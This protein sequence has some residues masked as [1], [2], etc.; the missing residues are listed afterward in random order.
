[1][2]EDLHFMQ[3]LDIPTN[4]KVVISRLPFKLRERWRAK[5]H[6]IWEASNDR[7]HFPDMV[8]FLER[9]VTLKVQA[10]HKGLLS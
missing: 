10:Y 3:E 1:M 4:M 8:A 9:H 5:A 6:D 2:M 7:A